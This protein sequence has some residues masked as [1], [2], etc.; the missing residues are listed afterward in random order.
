LKQASRTTYSP[1]TLLEQI[2][3]ETHK[4]QVDHYVEGTITDQEL[5]DQSPLIAINEGENPHIINLHLEWFFQALLNKLL[6][7]VP[8]YQLTP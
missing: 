1:I 7:Q 4:G 8:L 3:L 2:P 6:C 5:L